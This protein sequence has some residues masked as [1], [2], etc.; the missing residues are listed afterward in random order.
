MEEVPCKQPTVI[1]ILRPLSHWGRCRFSAS[2]GALLTPKKALK[3]PVLRCV[4]KCFSSAKVPKKK[5]Q[6]ERGLS[7]LQPEV[8]F[9]NAR[10]LM[11]E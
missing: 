11:P 10:K 5:L 3:T 2:S 4:F 8:L 7:V 1:I 9:D 6:Y